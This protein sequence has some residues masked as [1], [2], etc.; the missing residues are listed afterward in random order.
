MGVIGFYNDYPL[1]E[2]ISLNECFR[3]S[4]YVSSNEWQWID[5]EKT[6]HKIDM[7]GKFIIKTSIE[8]YVEFKNSMDER[9]K[10]LPKEN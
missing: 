9:I 2:Y 1:P 8:L 3:F 4:R 6:W 10:D 5:K 7:G